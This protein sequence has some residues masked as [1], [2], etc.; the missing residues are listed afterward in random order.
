MIPSRLIITIIILVQI[1]SGVSFAAE[2]NV[3]P[4]IV[5]EVEKEYPSSSQSLLMHLNQA[6][7]NE[8]LFTQDTG[9][10]FVISVDVNNESINYLSTAPRKVAAIVNIILSFGDYKSG[11]SFAQEIFRS[12]G[13]GTNEDLAIKN[14]IK[15]LNFSNSSKL[16]DFI[17]KGEDRV[18]KY[19]EENKAL[20]LSEIDAA[21]NNGDYEKAL[22][23]L[24]NV[25][26]FCSYYDEVVDK[27]MTTYNY[28]SNKND[29]MVLEEARIAWI[30]SPNQRGASEAENILSQLSPN[31]KYL[32]IARSLQNEINKELAAQR[33]HARSM[34]KK[35]QQHAMDMEREDKINQRKQIEAN[36]EISAKLIDSGT[37][38]QRSYINACR[39]IAQAYVKRNPTLIV[40]NRHYWR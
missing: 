13:V 35:A 19:F 37:Q 36:K 15:N 17:A 20:I 9:S 5:Q 25:P 8:G 11:I 29:M 40:V 22:F 26:A 16:K 24:N 7:L 4:I 10:Q 27:I 38:I 32:K 31:S 39:D 23:H 14:A 34:E 1:V 33:Q 18:A 6:L 28:L 30:N 12:K 3:T 21:I 2:F